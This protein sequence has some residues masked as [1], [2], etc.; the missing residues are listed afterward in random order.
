MKSSLRNTLLAVAFAI[1][2]VGCKN[3]EAERIA[4]LEKQP[5]ESASAAPV[6]ET[7]VADVK[8][9]GPLPSFQFEKSEHD[10]GTI[11]EGDIVEYTYSFVNNGE[12]PLIIQGA[13][14]SCGCTVPEWTKEPVPVGGKGFVK[15]KFNSS[16]KHDLQ[17]KTVTIT[18][19]TWPKQTVLKFTAMVKEKPA[20]K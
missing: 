19:N 13:Q 3:K 18:A 1:T 14:G 5:V 6:S 4:A 15:A 7:P 10:F 11:T 17:N 2:V 8:P 9:E 20:A 12:A 16:G